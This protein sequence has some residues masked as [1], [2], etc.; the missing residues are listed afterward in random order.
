RSDF[1]VKNQEDI[2]PVTANPERKTSLSPEAAE[3]IRHFEENIRA[4]QSGTMDPNDFKKFRLN[5]GVYGIRNETDRHMIRI[6][7]PHGEISADQLDAVA[8]VTEKYTRLKMGHVTTRQAIQIH[9]VHIN[10]LPT[11]LTTINASG[12]TSREACGNTV[13][14][15]TASPFAGLL[16]DEV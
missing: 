11:V 16:A 15:V 13:R 14:N 10:D 4:L 3:E 5:N 1:A 8:D 7:C 6:K 2:M 9:H 12:L